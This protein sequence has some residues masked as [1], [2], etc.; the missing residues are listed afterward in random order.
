MKHNIYCAQNS[1]F[2]TWNPVF[3]MTSVL[4]CWEGKFAKQNKRFACS[5]GVKFLFFHKITNMP[6]PKTH[7][8]TN[9][10]NSLGTGTQSITYK[11]RW[12]FLCVWGAMLW[13]DNRW[14]PTTSFWMMVLSATPLGLWEAQRW[15]H[16]GLNP[17]VTSYKV[18][19]L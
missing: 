4:T 12:I 8:H 7:T 5:D 14:G 2:M 3:F 9:R 17:V 15:L 16:S 6:M 1:P 13:N 10:N 19:T 11:T 18:I